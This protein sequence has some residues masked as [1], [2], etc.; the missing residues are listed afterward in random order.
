MFLDQCTI[1]PRHTGGYFFWILIT[2]TKNK[3]GRKNKQHYLYQYINEYPL[4]VYFISWS[5]V[6]SQFGGNLNNLCMY[7]KP[8]RF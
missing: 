6:P 3:K 1:K 7:V 8:F 5:A 4:E 2:N